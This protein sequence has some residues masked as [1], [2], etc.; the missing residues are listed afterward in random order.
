MVEE[1]RDRKFKGR[2]CVD[3]GKQRK[4]ITKEDVASPIVQLESIMLSLLVDA[5]KGRDVA[6][7]DVVG[8]YILADMNDYVLVKLNGEVENIRCDVNNRYIPFV[9]MKNDKKVIYMRL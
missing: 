2:A 6:T 1:K 3:G 7:T 4:Y 5:H 8:T 9:V